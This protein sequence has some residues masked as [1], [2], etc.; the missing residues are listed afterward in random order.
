MQRRR[1]SADAHARPLL[2]PL[3]TCDLPLLLS[4]A[5]LPQAVNALCLLLAVQ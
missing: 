2:A 5:C 1:A 3:P 4:G